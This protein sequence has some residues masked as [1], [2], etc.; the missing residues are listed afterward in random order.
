MWGLSIRCLGSP[1]SSLFSWY[2]HYFVPKKAI[3]IECSSPSSMKWLLSSEGL[4]LQ[5]ELC[6]GH[7]SVHLL[8]S[9]P[10]YLLWRA[11]LPHWFSA[12]YEED[13]ALSAPLLLETPC[14][15]IKQFALS[16]C[17]TQTGCL[18]LI[19]VSSFGSGWPPVT[20]HQ[21]STINLCGSAWLCIKHTGKRNLTWLEE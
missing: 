8:T 19:S 18:V 2:R 11:A 21:P 3:L 7:S 4:L 6:F 17:W 5:T 9:S 12:S 15:M 13:T 1:L 20:K 10:S 16:D 14:I